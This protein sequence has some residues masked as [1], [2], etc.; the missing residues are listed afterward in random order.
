[1][2]YEEPNQVA[3]VRKPLRR[4]E[5]LPSTSKPLRDCALC[6]QGAT[7]YL[8]GAAGAGHG[9]AEIG[10]GLRYQVDLC[11]D[12]FDESADHEREPHVFAGDMLSPV[13]LRT[14]SG[15]LPVGCAQER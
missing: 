8:R 15:A 11:S 10:F 2:P 3:D 14:A 6:G 4:A 9:P 7:S 13:R 5:G 1:M 12:L